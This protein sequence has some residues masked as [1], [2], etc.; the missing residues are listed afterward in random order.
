MREKMDSD[1]YYRIDHPLLHEL[2]LHDGKV[3]PAPFSGHING[4]G[5]GNRQAVE[6]KLHL[7][8]SNGPRAI[9][10]EWHDKIEIHGLTARLPDGTSAPIYE[11]G[12][13]RP[14]DEASRQQ[15][16]I[17]ISE[18]FELK[19]AELI[20]SLLAT[21]GTMKGPQAEK[22]LENMLHNLTIEWSQKDT[23]LQFGGFLYG[24]LALEIINQKQQGELLHAFNNLCDIGTNLR[25]YLQR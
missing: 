8:R 14:S 24:L 22:I 15:I 10:A 5:T 23:R 19:R 25:A 1:K 7:P 3:C 13:P 9:P 21:M 4:R 2:T 20:Q 18:R 12:T 6:G 16:A 11:R 17:E